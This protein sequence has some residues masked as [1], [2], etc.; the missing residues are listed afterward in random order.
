[1]LFFKFKYVDIYNHWLRWEVY[2][3]RIKVIYTLSIEIMID[4]FIK[5]LLS[6]KF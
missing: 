4:N 5:A 2:K 1:M 3:G 6:D